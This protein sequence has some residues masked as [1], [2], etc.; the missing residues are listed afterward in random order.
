MRML[1]PQLLR[2]ISH[3]P[4]NAMVCPCVSIYYACVFMVCVHSLCSCWIICP[5]LPPAR[6][7]PRGGGGKF[8]PRVGQQLVDLFQKANHIA[9]DF[10]MTTCGLQRR[11]TPTTTTKENIRQKKCTHPH[12]VSSLKPTHQS[13]PASHLRSASQNM[14]NSR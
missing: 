11:G 2:M 1:M 8:L 7:Q 4:I 10:F 3:L 9:K 5:H 13:L 14:A 12:L 6:L